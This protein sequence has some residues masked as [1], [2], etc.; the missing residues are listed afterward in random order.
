MKGYEAIIILTLIFNSINRHETTKLFS[1]TII[2]QVV[3]KY[4]IAR[5]LSRRIDVCVC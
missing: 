1:S 5:T 3:L 4:G 2:E